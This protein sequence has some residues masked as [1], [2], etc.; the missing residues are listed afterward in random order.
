MDLLAAANLADSVWVPGERGD[1][2]AIL[3][4]MD[5]F[6]LPSAA[7]GISNTILE[8]MASGLPVIAT[9]V[10][11]NPELVADGETGRLVPARDVASLSSILNE[12]AL[13]EQRRR[14][15]GEAALKR[16]LAEFLSTVWWLATSMCMTD[17]NLGRRDFICAA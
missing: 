13:D 7:E 6:V 8:A 1:I 15:F 5:I 3:R 12:L 14:R 16:I 9:D 2:P 17:N 10:G 4:A 11:G